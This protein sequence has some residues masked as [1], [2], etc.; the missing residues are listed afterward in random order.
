MPCWHIAKHVSPLASSLMCWLHQRQLTQVWSCGELEGWWAWELWPELQLFTMAV[1]MGVDGVWSSEQHIKKN[2]QGYQPSVCLGAVFCASPSV[3]FHI[4]LHQEHAVLRST[5]GRLKRCHAAACT[6]QERGAALAQLPAG[7]A[8][9]LRSR[10]AAQLVGSLLRV[11]CWR[12]QQWAIG[13]A[14]ARCYPWGPGLISLQHC[15]LLH[16]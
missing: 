13:L 6:A 11:A 7:A 9:R 8:L 12:E 1:E 10:E 16:R 3:G 15:L 2:Q 4:A 5:K 14:T